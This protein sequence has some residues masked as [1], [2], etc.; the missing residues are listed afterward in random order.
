MNV[1]SKVERGVS[2]ASS[3]SAGET[4]ALPGAIADAAWQANSLFGAKN[5][6]FG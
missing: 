1:G 4:P 6:L 2:P 3:K 5:S